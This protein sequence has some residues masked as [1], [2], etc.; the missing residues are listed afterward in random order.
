MI[1][2]ETIFTFDEVLKMQP[3]GDNQVSHELLDLAWDRWASAQPAAFEQHDEN[4][5]GTIEISSWGYAVTIQAV[6]R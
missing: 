6:E 2:Y 3:G 1:L 4:A 5:Y